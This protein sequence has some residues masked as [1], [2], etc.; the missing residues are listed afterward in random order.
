M[1]LEVRRV[2]DLPITVIDGDSPI[3]IYHQIE[4]NLK[5]IIANDLLAPGDLLPPEM[6]LSKAY[7]VSRQT[8]RV[9]LKRLEDAQ[10]ISR[11]QGRGTIVM[12]P[13]AT[14]IQFHLDRSFTRQMEELG[15]KPSSEVLEASQGF[16]AKD[17][18]PILQA[19]INQPILRLIR[20]R[21]GDDQ[22]IGYQDSTIIVSQCPDLH[23][24]DFNKVSLYEVL[25][26]YG[27]V[28][29]RIEHSVTATI[30]GDNLGG[31]LHIDV[32]DPLLVV[33][34]T[35]HANSFGVIEHTISTY[36]ADIY[37]YKTTMISS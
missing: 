32:G 7:G 34:T 11:Q 35:A 30:A 23:T 10:L 1:T 37:E 31:L 18:P 9:A 8:V 15:R 14:R 36:R 20:L 22:P 27:I 24:H 33:R 29:S 13:Q 5:Q 28:I 19:H 26:D 3:P 17:A 12:A 21:Y 6:E 2:T 25:S 4:Q 16:V